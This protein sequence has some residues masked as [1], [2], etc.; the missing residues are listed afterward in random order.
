MCIRDRLSVARP[1]QAVQLRIGEREFA[2]NN[3][4]TVLD[5]ANKQ[6]VEDVYKRQSESWRNT[7]PATTAPR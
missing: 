5:Q 7:T 3:Q 2:G 6:G 4:G 1:H